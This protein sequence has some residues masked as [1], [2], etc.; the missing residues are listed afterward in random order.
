M[1]NQAAKKCAGVLALALLLC[2]SGFSENKKSSF[3]AGLGWAGPGGSSLNG[4]FQTDFGFSLSITEKI[5]L[6][7]DFSYWKTAVEE[8]SGG[9]L[10][11]GELTMT[12]FLGG[13]RLD[14]SSHSFISPYLFGGI[15]YV[16]ST[17]RMGDVVTIPEVSITQRINSGIG[18]QGGGGVLFRVTESIG[19]FLE[20]LYMA[21]SAS[22][23]TTIRDL[24]LGVTTDDFSL[25]LNTLIVHVGIKYFVGL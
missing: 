16:V 3:H 17:F 13:I 4:S 24:N 15:G 20:G 21:R 1:M 5:S 19:I 22:G 14:L 2:S 8:Q 7:L 11:N 25:N 18:F 6:V 9:D 12:P 23:T 10:L